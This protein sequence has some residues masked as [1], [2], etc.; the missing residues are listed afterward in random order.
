MLIL[1]PDASDVAVRFKND[2]IPLACKHLNNPGISETTKIKAIDFLL[3]EASK[4]VQV[5]AKAIS[6]Y[7]IERRDFKL[8]E[9]CVGICGGKDGFL[10]FT[11]EK[12]VEAA[13]TF[14]F[15][16]IKPRYF[17]VDLSCIENL[18]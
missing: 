17:S 9:R 6:S 5:V 12:L 2:N 3:T 14:G 11:P 15:D 4:N 8:W 7:A 18:I 10:S 1:W 16:N 13:T